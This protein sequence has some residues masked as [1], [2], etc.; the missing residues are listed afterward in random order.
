MAETPSKTDYAFTSD[1]RG[2]TNLS[3]QVTGGIVVQGNYYGPGSP[4]APNSGNENLSSIQSLLRKIYAKSYRSVIPVSS[5]DFYFDIKEKWVNLTLKLEGDS[6]V[7]EDYAD[8][9][10]KAFADADMLIIEGDP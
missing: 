10:K 3:G 8:L 9:L 7:T 1:I 4:T 6:A 2:G 5:A